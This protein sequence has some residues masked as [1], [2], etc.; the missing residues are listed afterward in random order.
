[1]KHPTDTGPSPARSGPPLRIYVVRHAETA[2]SLAGRHTGRTDLPLTAHGQDMARTL[3]TAL[4]GVAFSRV[5]TSPSGRSRA[6]CELAGLGA[7]AITDAGLAEWDYGKCEGMRTCEIRQR[8]PAW[9][10][11][12][13]GC[14]SG[15]TPARVATRADLLITR[16]QDGDGPVAV[17]THGHFGRALAAR[18]IGLPVAQGRHFA[19]GPASVGILGC[20]THHPTRRVIALWNSFAGAVVAPHVRQHTDETAPVADHRRNTHSE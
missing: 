15:E 18:W 17:F 11:W 3:A 16:L 4:A 9:D 14:P 19:M 1:M 6:T 7:T 2:W 13:D 10:I 5:L 8:M 12:L 20:D